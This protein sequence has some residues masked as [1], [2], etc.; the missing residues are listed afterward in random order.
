MTSSNGRLALIDARGN[1]AAA[2]PFA[3]LLAHWQRKHSRAVY[4]PGVRRREPSPA[5]RYSGRVTLGRGTD[6]LR[7]LDAFA[8]GKVYYDPG[9]KVEE[10][11][12][13]RR[14]K[15]RNQFRVKSSE[16]SVLYTSFEE[17][18]A[19]DAGQKS[20]AAVGVPIA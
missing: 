6:Y 12:G 14:Q 20:A 3:S 5:Y 11:S 18:S 15:R 16:L 9:I 8:T 4:V 1:V 7:L 17:D 19:C 10:M 13:A 2:W